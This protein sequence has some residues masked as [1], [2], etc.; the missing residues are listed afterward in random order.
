MQ[1]YY[2]FVRFATRYPKISY[3]K[4]SL[5]MIDFNK[6]LTMGKIGNQHVNIHVAFFKKNGFV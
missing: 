5:N 2:Y 6:V 1:N 4:L 3:N